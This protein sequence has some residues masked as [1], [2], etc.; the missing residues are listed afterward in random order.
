MARRSGHMALPVAILV[1]AGGLASW[2]WPAAPGTAGPPRAF[3][4][5]AS[6]MRR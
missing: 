3:A 4:S 2:S 1:L 6:S 5:G